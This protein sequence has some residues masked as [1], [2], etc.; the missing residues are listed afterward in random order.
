MDIVTQL[1]QMTLGRADIVGLGLLRALW[2][3]VWSFSVWGFRALGCLAVVVTVVK[4][5]RA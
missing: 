3:F 4:A 5:K 1:R 2:V